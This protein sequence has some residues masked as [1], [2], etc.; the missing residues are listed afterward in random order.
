MLRSLKDLHIKRKSRDRGEMGEWPEEKTQESK[1]K[2]KT[3]GTR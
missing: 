1:E 2:E 3:S